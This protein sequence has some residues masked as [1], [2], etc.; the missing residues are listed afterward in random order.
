MKIKV[1][2]N[3]V[4]LICNKDCGRSNI[5]GMHLSSE[6]NM[7]ST[8]YTIQHIF[9]NN[10]PTCKCGCGQTVTVCKYEYQDYH[11]G[12]NPNCHWQTKYTPDSEEYIKRRDMVSDTLKQYYANNPKVCSPEFGKEW[13]IKRKKYFSENP[14]K[15]MEC[16]DKMKATKQRQSSLGLLS[17]E[18]HFYSKFTAEQRAAHYAKRTLT[19][20][21]KTPEEKMELSLIY[22]ERSRSAWAVLSE[23][24]RKIWCQNIKIGINNMSEET[25]QNKWTNHS[26][27][28]KESMCRVNGTR[29]LRPLYNKDTIPYIV[30]VL[31]VRYE[32][33]FIHGQ[34]EHGEFRIVDSEL[35]RIYFADAYCPR[36]NLWVEFDEPNKFTGGQLKLE[37]LQRED[38]IRAVLNCEIIRI[39]FDKKLHTTELNIFD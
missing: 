14:E 3:S 5:L 33:E 20:Q 34:S 6:H 2:K 38:R 39:Y 21:S 31:N 27:R 17:G 13:A 9:Q 7:T 36:L 28:M 24:E 11:V 15:L 22:S 32:T 29:S 16:I 12:H 10:L 26:K 19:R 25:K 8:Q 4:C 30:D 18:N 23:D 1:L 37:H 35:D